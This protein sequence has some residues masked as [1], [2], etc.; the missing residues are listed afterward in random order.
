MPSTT[1]PHER[2]VAVERPGRMADHRVEFAAGA[3]VGREIA[4]YST[5]A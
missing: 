4:T 5:L 3:G 1:R 2:N